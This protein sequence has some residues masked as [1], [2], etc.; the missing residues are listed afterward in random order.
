MSKGN[1]PVGDLAYRVNGLAM[2]VH[3]EL[4]RGFHEVVY[5]DALEYELKQAGINMKGKNLTKFFIVI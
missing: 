5:K 2:K 1:L 3:R 4:G